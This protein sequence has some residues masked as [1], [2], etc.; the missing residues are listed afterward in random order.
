MWNERDKYTK[1]HYEISEN[2]KNAISRAVR[3]MQDV[4]GHVID[5]MP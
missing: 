1:V 3:I 4:L 2:T 5:T